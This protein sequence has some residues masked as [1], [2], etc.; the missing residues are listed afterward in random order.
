MR[1]NQRI[2]NELSHPVTYKL[3]NYLQ[4]SPAPAPA[5]A[6]AW[7]PML[8][9]PLEEGKQEMVLL[10]APP[11]C[12]KSTMARK[13]VE[14][15]YVRINQDSLGSLPKCVT[16]A[17]N[18]LRKGLSVCIDNTNFVPQT[19]KSWI[20]IAREFNVKVV[21]FISPLSSSPFFFVPEL[22]MNGNRFEPLFWILPKKCAHYSPP[23]AW[24]THRPHQK[25][26]GRSRR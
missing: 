4:S 1:S 22:T 18:A 10:V 20:E 26:D 8:F 2:D 9:R 13:F 24:S 21:S 6:G 7:D 11:A 12:G 16:E 15:G 5:G 19:R 17:K 14:L 3:A 23:I 25:T